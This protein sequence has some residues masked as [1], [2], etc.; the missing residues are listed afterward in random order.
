VKSAGTTSKNK[1]YEGG[2]YVDY[3]EVK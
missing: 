1:G 2:Q 3:E